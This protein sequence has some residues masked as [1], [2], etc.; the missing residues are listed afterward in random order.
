[1]PLSSCPLL[2][3]CPIPTS[4]LLHHPRLLSHLMLMSSCPLLLPDLCQALVPSQVLVPQAPVPISSCT[5]PGYS[6]SQALAHS[7]SLPRLLP[8]LR[9]CHP[10]RPLHPLSPCPMRYSGLCQTV[11]S[12]VHAPSH[13]HVPSQDPA[14][15]QASEELSPP[16]L[17]APPTP[18]PL[19][20]FLAPAPYQAPVFSP[21]LHL[22]P[23][24]P[25]P[26]HPPVPTQTPA[27]SH[28]YV[29]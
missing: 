3:S 18:L 24:P 13:C 8:A 4:R 26:L 19:F 21:L 16:M 6:P 25:R 9:L 1:M 27:P 23:A 10:P 20:P 11:P 2:G 17:P 28:A 29:P 14:P 5:L 12:R 7:M 15:S 22:P